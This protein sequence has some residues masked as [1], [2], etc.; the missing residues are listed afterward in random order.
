[1]AE[2][3]YKMFKVDKIE[4]MGQIHGV[5][6]QLGMGEFRTE[7][8]MLIQVKQ[9]RQDVADASSREWG[10]IGQRAAIASCRWTRQRIDEDVDEQ[11]VQDLALNVDNV[12]QAND[13]DTFDFDV[14][15]ALMAQTMFM[16]NLSS[17]DP[18]YVEAGPS[19]DSY[20]LS[21]VHD[22]DQYQD[23]VCEH[24]EE[25]AMHD[26]VQLNPIFDS[27]T[28][29]TTDSNMIPYN[30][31]VKDNAVPVVHKLEAKLSNL[32][33]KSHNDNHD[34]L[35]NR[36]SNLEVNHLNLQLKYQNL[37]DSL[38]NNPPTP[39][40]DTPDFDSVFVLGKMQASLQGK[41]NVIRQLKR[42]ISHLQ[43]THSDTDRTLKVKAI[44]SQITQLTEKVTVLQAQNDSFRAKN[45][46]IKQH[47]KELN[48]REAHLDYLMHLKESVET[49]RDILEEAK[50]VRPLDS[51]IVSACRYT[52]HSQEL[53]E[54]AIGT[55]PQ[56]SHQRD[57]KYAPAPLIRKKQVTFTEQCDKSHSNT[58]KH[59]AKLANQK[60]NV[61]VPPSTGVN[62]CTDASGSQPRSNTKKHR[63]SPAKGCSKHMTGDHSRLMNFMKKFIGTV[64]FRNDHFG[65]IMGYGDYVI[66]DSVISRVYYVE[67][68]RHNLF[69]VRQICD[70]DLEVAFRKHSCYVRDTDGVKLIKGSR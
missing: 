39:D 69:F 49:I 21:E 56:D 18:V 13:C 47:Y 51:L 9:D 22:H 6:V 43:K 58:R 35:A 50:V 65:A 32:R 3:W 40:K 64:R 67:G 63:I 30:L 27:H 31:Y 26:N 54:Y 46:K 7:L 1:M 15:E 8:G 42:Q 29:Y 38:G 28:N 48:N 5:E 61:H 37:K 60:T 17:T 53:L 12:F 2:L 14:D 55:C 25:P 36:F 16:A 44:D 52:K 45:D 33:D 57:K 23:V 41:D 34:E 66:G 68:L 4:V 59:V 24:H 10:G 20:I 11:P 19:F 70:A 62:R